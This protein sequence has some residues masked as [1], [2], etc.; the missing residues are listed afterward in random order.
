MLGAARRR[1]RARPVRRL[2]RAGHRGA[3][4]RRGDGACSSSATRRAVDVIRANLEALGLGEDEARVVH[5]PARAALRD[6][7]ARGDAYDLVF[8]DPPYRDAPA[9]GRELSEA[10][11]AVLAPGGAR[12]DRERPPRAAASSICRSTDERRY[13]DTLIRIHTWH[14]I[15]ASPS[16]PAPTTRSPTGTS[17]SSRAR[18][19]SSTRSSSASSTSRCA[20][21]RRCSTPRSA[22]RF[23]DEATAHLGNVRAEPF[24]VL[25][26]EFA[27]RL[28]ARAIVKG[29]RAISRLR[30]RD[31]D[32]PAQPPAGARRRHR[33]TSWPARSTVSSARVAS[34]SSRSS[35]ASIEDL[36]PAAV[37]RR[38]KEELA[39]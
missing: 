23:I 13:G 26:V 2:G 11:P 38:L 16:A 8:L 28:G 1:A 3:L 36:V 4:A 19:S 7:S 39:R 15:P 20:R 33:S 10:L 6:A 17:T 18:R 12:R 30:V 22:S 35:M 24:D 31:G 32:E 14:L 21:A 37:A 25:V 27:R 34:R 5:A 9:L 29:L